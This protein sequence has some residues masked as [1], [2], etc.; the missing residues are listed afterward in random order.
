MIILNY[1]ILL[2]FSGSRIFFP[3]LEFQVI[4]DFLEFQKKSRLPSLK[5][6][7]EPG[8]FFSSLGFGLQ[9]AIYPCRKK[10]GTNQIFRKW[11]VRE[12]SS[13]LCKCMSM[14]YS[15]DNLQTCGQVQS[16]TLQFF[17]QNTDLIHI[18]KLVIKH[19]PMQHL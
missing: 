3:F 5:L 18:Q 11:L 17:K 16:E 4:F 2:F 9:T 6:L 12:I 1:E 19:Q 8:P 10:Q 13:K 15:S 14:M 7:T